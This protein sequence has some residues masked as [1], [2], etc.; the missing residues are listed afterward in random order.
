MR[1]HY[2]AKSETN[3]SQEIPQT[4]Q[5]NLVEQVRHGKQSSIKIVIIRLLT[6]FFCLAFWYGVYKLVKL[7]IS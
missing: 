5:I 1:K 4:K 7:F 6:L 2:S 3:A